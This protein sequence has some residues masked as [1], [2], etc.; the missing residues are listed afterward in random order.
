M[1][2]SMLKWDSYPEKDKLGTVLKKGSLDIVK[3]RK[4]DSKLFRSDTSQIFRHYQDFS[5]KGFKLC[6]AGKKA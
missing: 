4:I 2:T 5:K 1:N 3:H 6:E